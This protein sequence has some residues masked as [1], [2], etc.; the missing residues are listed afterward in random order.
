MNSRFITK[1]V[2]YCLFLILV[3]SIATIV[4]NFMQINL[5]NNYFLKDYYSEETFI[6]LA[7][8]N[9][10]RIELIGIIKLIIVISSPFLIGRWFYISAKMNHLLEKKDLTI[11][12][13]WS[14]GWYFIPFAN[15]VMPYH[16]LTETYK[17][18]FDREDWQ[19]QP[20]SIDIPIWWAAFLIGGFLDRISL[21]MVMGL[22]ESYEYIE[23]NKISYIN[24]TSDILLIINA[25]CLFRIISTVANN[26]K[27]LNIDLALNKSSDLVSEKHIQS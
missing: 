11:T 24:I 1:L 20:T 12:P 14:V 3:I 10:Q 19:N 26:H 17:A 23:L 25:I 21:K 9:D 22:G 16:S 27:H 15:I 8:K 13:G 2:K 6:V 7:D 5:L 18:S 4:A